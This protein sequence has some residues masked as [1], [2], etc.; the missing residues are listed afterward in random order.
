[1]L[2]CSLLKGHL[3]GTTAVPMEQQR[4][5]DAWSWFLCG[6]GGQLLLCMLEGDPKEA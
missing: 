5:W 6:G 2:E 4:L 3:P 1:M